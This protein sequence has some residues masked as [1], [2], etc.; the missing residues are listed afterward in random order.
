M[1]MSY[2]EPEPE[3]PAQPLAPPADDELAALEMRL[4]PA[5]AQL[6]RLASGLAMG[7]AY[8]ASPVMGAWYCNAWGRVDVCA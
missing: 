6:L 1:R 2:K 3:P 8:L 4:P 5:V 7:G